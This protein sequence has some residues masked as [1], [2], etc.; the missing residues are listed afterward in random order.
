MTTLQ[1]RAYLATLR[2]S[3]VAVIN[4]EYESFI[5]L[6]LGLRNAAVSNS[7]AII[8][9][10]VLSIRNEVLLV[11]ETLQEMREEMESV[12]QVRKGVREGKAV[13][14]R[15]LEVEGAVEKVESLLMIGEGSVRITKGRDHDQ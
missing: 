10:P 6:S 2:S 9:R 15:L 4:E 12:L 13:L 8:K 1:L 7:L 14:R 3:L 5:G 11:K